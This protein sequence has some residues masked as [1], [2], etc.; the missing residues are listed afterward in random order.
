MNYHLDIANKLDG[1]VILSPAVSEGM[2]S[3]AWLQR[4]ASLVIEGVDMIILAARRKITLVSLIK[5]I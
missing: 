5:I 3:S 4:N 1:G 2:S